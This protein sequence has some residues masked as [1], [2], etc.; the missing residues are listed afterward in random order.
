MGKSKYLKHIDDVIN[1]LHGFYHHSH[2]NHAHLEE[3]QIE[4]GEA[5]FHLQRLFPI[6][7]ITSR[8]RICQKILRHFKVIATDLQNFVCDDT[9]DCDKVGDADDILSELTDRTFV[10][11]IT[12]FADVSQI[13]SKVSLDL[14]KS[15]KS[16]IGTCN[17]RKKLIDELIDLRRWR[18]GIQ[19]DKLAENLRCGRN[20]HCFDLEDFEDSDTVKFR[21]IQLLYSSKLWMKGIIAPK[22]SSV[23]DT[24]INNI[25]QEFPTIF[26]ERLHGD[27]DMF[28]PKLLG[29]F[30]QQTQTESLE[31]EEDEPSIEIPNLESGETEQLENELYSLLD[32]E[33]WTLDERWLRLNRYFKLVMPVG[34]VSSRRLA[35]QYTE[36]VNSILGHSTFDNHKELPA[37]LF[38]QNFVDVP[39]IRWTN[40]LKSIVQHILSIPASTASCESSFS[41][42]SKEKTKFRSNLNVETVEA[43]LRVRHNI[44]DDI[45]DEQLA[46]YAR[47]WTRTHFRSD[48]R[49]FTNRPRGGET[50][51]AESNRKHI[52]FSPS[53]FDGSMMP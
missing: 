13:F 7:W 25:V 9:A 15:C 42:Y 39:G 19:N 6:R 22:L 24:Y 20:R 10:N 23:R 18:S 21:D 32:Q 49:P 37:E 1:K 41:Y 30:K 44:P 53:I 45:D 16:V 31:S 11:T 47:E 27:L 46:Y 38:W 8:Y 2:I 43:L 5:R 50:T 52:P 48:E 26:V 51:P 3:F 34:Q 28:E 4:E 12:F 40:P 36:L 33:T 35:E 17:Q 14:Q 29:T